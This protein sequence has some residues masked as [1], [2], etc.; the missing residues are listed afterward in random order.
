M[1]KSLI[2][3]LM[4]VLL[5]SML[6]AGGSKAS[7]QT[8]PSSGS[9]KKVIH[10]F[11]YL[12]TSGGPAMVE[13]IEA[14]YTKLNPNITFENSV[15]NQGTDY[16]P[17]LATALASGE[18]P[19]IIMGNAG[20]YPDLIA[21]GYAMN[22][23][24]NAVLKRLNLPAGD[25]GDV[26][27]NGIVYGFPIDIKTWGVFYNVEIFNKLGLK[28]AKTQSELM[29]ICKKLAAAGID[30]WVHSFGD[31]VYGDIE[32]RNT[33][34]TRALDAG[35]KDLFDALMSG[36]KKFT[37]YPYF[38]EGLK[39]WQ[40]RM[41]WSRKDSMSNNQDKAQEVFVAGQAAMYYTGVWAISGLVLKNKDFKFDFFLAPIDENPN[42]Q[43]MNVQVDTALMVNP[44]AKNSD[45]AL[46]F[47][48]WWITDGAATWSSIYQVATTTGKVSDDVVPVVKSVAAIKASGAVSGYGAFTKPFNAEYTQAWRRGLTA[49]AESVITGGR[50]TPEQ[51]LAN[52]QSLFDNI[53]AT[54]K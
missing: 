15:Y 18:Q 13:K 1:K 35:D 32:M 24:N 17:Q 29:D 31:A 22:L 54:T 42:S 27:S 9:E 12:I 26:S 37:D 52:L 10:V 3:L 43:K 25:L 50:M 16:F 47:L 21:N 48:E 20:M 39:V 30:P 44:K 41:Q 28:P 45:E 49:F 14:A 51:C 46:K 40:Q 23:T 8:A 5:G 36:R 7:T 2:F 34:W 11:H 53:R 4:F 38:L 19:N 33:V 6:F